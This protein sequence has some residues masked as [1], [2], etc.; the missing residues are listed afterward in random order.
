MVY[1]ISIPGL[2]SSISMADEIFAIK[3][4]ETAKTAAFF[5]L[6]LC[7]ICI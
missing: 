4:A 3:T 1:K 6:K 5:M 7:R 2:T